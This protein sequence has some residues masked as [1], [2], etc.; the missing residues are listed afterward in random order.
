MG[1]WDAVAEPA[2]FLIL[3]ACWPTPGDHR[4]HDAPAT[5]TYETI[6]RARF[7]H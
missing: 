7:G 6:R 2:Q 5:L 1:L 4:A 3:R